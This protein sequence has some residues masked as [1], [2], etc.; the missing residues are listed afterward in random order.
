MP[1]GRGKRAHAE[2]RPAH[3]RKRVSARD[4][5][6]GREMGRHGEGSSA[7]LH[8]AASPVEV[9]V[10]ILRQG[11]RRAG[12][13]RGGKG[14][15]GRHRPSGRDRTLFSEKRARKGMAGRAIGSVRE[16]PPHARRVPA[17]WMRACGSRHARARKV[18]T[19]RGGSPQVPK[20]QLTLISP[21]SAKASCKSSSCASSLTLVT[22]TIHPSTAGERGQGQERVGVAGK[23][24]KREAE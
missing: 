2:C 21:N 18:T 1:S 19:K 7:R 12:K 4:R 22:S 13:G 8:E 17:H 24:K 10:E 16:R 3:A 11:R 9:E 15:E 14:K 6:E 23:K 20:A 5:E